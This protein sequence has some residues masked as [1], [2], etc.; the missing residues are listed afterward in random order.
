[1]LSNV[2]LVTAVLSFFGGLIVFADLLIG[3]LSIPALGEQERAAVVF[4]RV[5]IIVAARNEDREIR[6]ALQS[7]LAQDYPNFEV[8]AVN[9]RSEDRTGLILD[10]MRTSHPNLQVLHIANLPSGWLGKNHAL[11]SGVNAGDGELLLFTDADVK[12]DPSVLS[13]AVGFITRHNADHLTVAPYIVPGSVPL[14]LAVQYFMLAF[15]VYMRPWKA[16]D[17]KSRHFMG[18]GAFNLVRRSAYEKAGTF[19]RIPLR[20]DDD[21]MLAKI[22]KRSGASQHIVTG[23][24]MLSIK[25]YSTLREL[26]SG[27]QKNAFA[28]LNYSVLLLI[29]SILGTV[30]LGIW[31]FIAVFVTT[32]IT[33]GLYAGSCVLLM[34]M[35]AGGAAIQK[36]RPW[37]APAYPVAAAI[38]AYI[39]LTASART[40]LNGGIRW[41]GTR[42][43]L[44]EL[45]SNKV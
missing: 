26:I 15:T 18:I 28:G 41:R 21:I 42:Y 34:A 11:F 35:Y 25:W 22:L 36:N 5:S 13:R 8:I 3:N 43:S 27:F 37:L 14:S 17:P 19:R 2:L 32:G 20:P 1:M 40:I 10:E 39:L 24:G 30:L 45:R 38:F 44:Q 9:D 12:Y 29:A 7:V 6:S 33:R 31:P 4:P 16:R 23:Q